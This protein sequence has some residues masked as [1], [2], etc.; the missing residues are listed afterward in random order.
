MK[1]ASRWFSLSLLICAISSSYA[2][3]QVKPVLTISFDNDLSGVGSKG[4]VVGAAVGKPE[5]VPGRSGQALKTGET[6][7]YVE[8]P[9]EGILSRLGGT[10]E[11]WV[12]P[13]DWKPEGQANHF[14]FDAGGKGSVSLGAYPSA[15]PDYERNLQIT[16]SNGVSGDQP[17]WTTFP[18]KDWAQGQWHHIAA[19]WSDTSGVMCYVDGKPAGASPILVQGSMPEALGKVFAIGDHYGKPDQKSSVLVDDVRIYDRALTPADIAAHSAGDYSFVTKLSPE[20]TALDFDI[21]ANTNTAVVRMDINSADVD[22]A[23]LKAGFAVVPKGSP[24]PEQPLVLTFSAGQ[25]QA[26]LPLP[27]QK[28]GQYEVVARVQREGAL[29]CEKRVELI[30]PRTDWLGSK[31]GLEDKVLPPWTPMRVQKTAKGTTVKCWGRSYS[32]GKGAFLASQIESGGASLLSR[33]L[34]LQL[35]SSGG[36]AGLNAQSYRVASSSDTRVVLVGNAIA[37]LGNMPCAL[38][39]RVTAEYDGLTLFEISAGNLS[40]AQL[41]DVTIDIPIRPEHALYRHRYMP[42]WVSKSGNV[43]EGMGVVDKAPFSPFVWLGDNDRGLFW[44][45]ESDEM[46]PNGA[47]D[48][49]IEIVRS[50]KEIVLRLHLLAKGQ[51]LPENWKFVFGL[52][53]TP[54]KPLPK[55]WRK[56]RLDYNGSRYRVRNANGKVPWPEAILKDSYSFGW[57]RPNDPA[58]FTEFVKGLHAKGLKVIPYLCLAWVDDGTPEYKYFHRLWDQGPFDP[59]A[60]AVGYKSR[61]VMTSPLGKG[62]SDFLTTSMKDFLDRYEIDGEYHDMTLPWS[63]SKVDTGTG[64]MRDGKAYPVFPIMAYRALYRRNYAVLKSLKRETFA[65]GH[66]SGALTIPMIA[67]EDSYLDGEH[68]R[69]AG[70]KGDY[71]DLISLDTFR[72]EYMGRQFGLMPFFLPEFRGEYAEQVE[73]TRGMMALLMIHDVTLWPMWC[74]VDVV[75]EAL[76]ALDEFGYVDSDFIPYFDPTPPATT[77]M[78]DVYI[79]AYKR[80]DG[81]ALLIIGNMSKEDRQGAV[82]INAKR[83]GVPLAHVTSWSDKTPISVI[84]DTVQLQVPGRGYRMLL[85]EKKP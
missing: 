81:R 37:E 71:M 7:G 83:L 21:D 60:S 34:S 73:P 38:T 55:D 82:R 17:A 24:F 85:V 72:C 57:P 51:K 8:Y 23:S 74:N 11:M 77:D 14:F 80:R 65:M 56:W 39:A 63:S 41:D 40:K 54:V 50:A 42:T 84:Q 49:A 6:T 15:N 61:F 4:P 78:N 67:Y 35:R 22:E 70:L 25:T 79:S 16:A 28:P 30:I 46:W 19:T 62:F 31:L 13:V 66:C 26:T 75:N 59:I 18:I 45:C 76:K 43:P 68:L 53:A 5:F 10:V 3:A 27:Y 64:Y 12:S 2:F 58:A 47:S 32:F 1:A 36:A 44:F 20:T 33:P 48:N 69:D 29:V 52:Q 9:T